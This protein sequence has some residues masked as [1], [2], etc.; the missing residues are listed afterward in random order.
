VAKTNNH[1]ESATRQQL[2]QAALKSFARRGYAAASVQEIVDA[3]RVSKPVLYYYFADKAQ[4]FQALVDQAHDERY[5]LMQE[6]ADRG[7]SVAAKLEEIVAAVF[8]FAL[9]NRELMRLAFATAFAA[10]GEAPG[11][12]RCREKGRRNYEFVR[13]LVEAGQASGELSRRFSADELAMGIYGQLNSYVMIRLLVPDCPLDR[14][15]AKQIVRLFL[16]GAGA[17]QPASGR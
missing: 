10:D 1:A 5:R 8:E 14:Q 16:A 12:T 9:R 13:S 15:A 17:R 7:G 11:G 4:L 3:A 2:L 6:A